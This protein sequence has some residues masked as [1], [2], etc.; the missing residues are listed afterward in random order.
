MMPS[1][2][3][4]KT[5][6]RSA[7]RMTS[8]P[9]APEFL[10]IASDNAFIPGANI[11]IKWFKYISQVIVINQNNITVRIV[12][13]TEAHALNKQFRGKDYATNVLSF[14]SD[15][16]Q[17]IESDYLGDIVICAA[18]VEQEAI[19]QNKTMDA[20]WAHMLVHGILHLKGYDHIQTA[21]A[22][23]MEGLETA[24]LSEIGYADPYAEQ[25]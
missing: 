7:R 6:E 12:D 22:E 21:Q 5:G 8:G 13:R 1:K 10:Q 24:I 2:K 17:D 15:I 25:A 16:P 9:E 18:V 23:E 20:H 11:F 4:R 19:A 3:A 14:P